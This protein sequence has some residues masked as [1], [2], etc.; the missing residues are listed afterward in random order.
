[1]SRK[2]ISLAEKLDA[3]LLAL[4][5]A[6]GTPIPR[7]EAMKLKAG[8]VARLFQFDHFPVPVALGG[9]NRPANLV[10]RLIAAHRERT[11]KID[12]PAIAK[13]R[14]RAADHEEHRRRILAKSGQGE[15]A[16]KRSRWGTRKL[17]TKGAKLQSR[18][19]FEKRPR[20]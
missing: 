2:S 9:D 18:S 20:P 10:P 11:A 4:L 7:A 15:A 13:V 6:Q 3:A 19:S 12:V 17:N 16:P 8:D 5:E 14:R 1:M